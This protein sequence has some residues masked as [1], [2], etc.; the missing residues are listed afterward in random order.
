MRL[1]MR[2][3]KE[4][5]ESVCDRYR[6]SGR[7]AKKVMPCHNPVVYTTGAIAADAGFPLRRGDCCTQDPIR[8]LPSRLGIARVAS[9]RSR[10]LQQRHP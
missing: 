1:S 2:S 10:V 8:M 5:T 4:L 9:G 7:R 3:R 6:R